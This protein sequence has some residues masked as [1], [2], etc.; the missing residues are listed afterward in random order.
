MFYSA[1]VPKRAQN[2]SAVYDVWSAEKVILKLWSREYVLI[3]LKVAIPEGYYGRVV[4]HSSMAKRYGMI[5]HNGTIDLDY[6]RIVSVILFNF[7][8]KECVIERGDCIAHVIFERYYIPKFIEV[9]EFA[10]EKTK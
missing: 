10:N 5:F 1:H 8:N 7:C 4:G 3:D 6:H 2:A 9:P